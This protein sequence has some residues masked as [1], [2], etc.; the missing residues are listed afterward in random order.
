MGALDSVQLHY[1]STAKDVAQFT[2]WLHD[3]P[4][5]FLGIDTETS[6]FNPFKDQIRL[7]QFGDLNHGWAIPWGRWG[8]LAIDAINSYSGPLVLHNSPFDIRFIVNHTKGEL[9][10]WNWAATH[11]TMT[12]AHII[13][14]NAPKGL[15]PLAAKLVDKLAVAAQQTLDTGMSA[16]KWTWGTVPL[17]Y[18][19]YWIYAAMD[20]V[21]TCH[22]LEKLYPTIT[23]YYS[24]SYQLEMQAIELVTGMMLKGAKIDPGYCQ[25]TMD[26]LHQFSLDSRQYLFDK[27][28]IENAT[29]SVQL[30]RVLEAEG[31][32]LLGK[33]TK[34]GAQALDKEVLEA[35][36]HEVADLA[37]KIKQA[38][39]LVSTYFTNLIAATDEEGRVHPTI[40]PQGTKTGRMTITGPALQTLPRQSPVRGAFVPKEGHV[41]ISI[42]ADQ[43]EARLAAH[44]ADDAG[45]LGAFDGGDFFVNLARQVF[46]DPTIEKDD[47][48]RARTKGVVYGKLYGAGPAK[49]AQT[50]KVPLASMEA[51]VAAFEEAFPGIKHLQNQTTAVAKMRGR[52]EGRAYIKT[53]YGK[54]IT[55]EADR[56]YTAMNYLIQGCL[57][58]DSTVL[59]REGW[60]RIDSF[61]DGTEVWTGKAWAPAVKIYRGRDTRVR[62]HLR[63]GRTFDCDSRHKLLGARRGTQERWLS[64]DD[65]EQDTLAGR[66]VADQY[67]L[68]RDWKHELP[69]WGRHD[70]AETWYWVGRFY[71]DG[72]VASGN[73]WSLAFNYTPGHR[74]NAAAEAFVSW[75]TRNTD[76]F[77]GATNSTRGFTVSRSPHG[78]I[79]TVSGGTKAGFAFWQRYGLHRGTRGR[80]R[81]F[82]AELFSL[83]TCCRRAFINGLF[84]ADG[85]M[86]NGEFHKLT[87]VNERMAIGFLKLLD[88]V[89]LPAKLTRAT[90]GWFDI[91]IQQKSPRHVTVDRV[92]RLNTDEHTWTLG[93]NHPDH[94][95][96]T[97]GLIS[98][99]SAAEIF[100]RTL[101][102]LATAGFAE[103]LMIPVH[104][105]ILMEVPEEL[106]EE[107]LT[108]AVEVMNDFTSFK[109]PITWSGDIMSGSW[110]EKYA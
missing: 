1:A 35:A 99:N 94:S 4:R 37:L 88:T 44:F 33:Q 3:S 5:S 54:P 27:Y 57:F 101:A 55:V 29:S 8:G 68:T 39:K 105:E 81:E 96:A 32:V 98:K 107:L 72:T 36:D 103:Y 40:W 13:D 46:Q 11:D 56:E 12:M 87:T 60:T 41:L 47:P 67:R 90:A 38:D 78:T 108:S 86:R 21:L 53:L 85:T 31:V 49:M 102:R 18:G 70:D 62:L 9:R 28:K 64:V 63:D 24:E 74:D 69:E 59:T 104:D 34:G 42:D 82:P 2:E 51:T 19:P 71:G 65:L 14:S 95:F 20:P 58:A 17:T 83:D 92:E 89:G 76:K 16:N 10:Q 106:A 52:S 6:G 61:I 91:S 73:S 97:E 80:D 25:T 79:A 45:M 48:R 109:V 100:K 26:E 84:G 23:E 30:K 77:V 50:A 75:M 7:I 93:V 15:K 66:A 22:I 43:I 110:G